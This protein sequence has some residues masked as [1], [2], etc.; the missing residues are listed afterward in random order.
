MLEA[1][2]KLTTNFGYLFEEDLISEISEL[3][4]S[5][6]FIEDSKII[7]VGDY[8]RSMP[9]LISGA[10]KILREDEH[11]EELV[12]YYLEKGDTCAMTLSCCMGQ[13]KS[14]IR[15]VA[16]TNVE[17][18]MLPKE[19]MLEWLGKYKTWQTYI[20]QSYHSRMDELL[21]AVD[22]IAFL[23][24]DERL[25]KYL[26]DKAMVVH[27]DVLHVTHKEISEDLHT[28]RVVISRL[29]KKLENEGKIKLFRN[30][31]KVLEL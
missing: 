26:K 4:I 12:L 1:I 24:M 16:E 18:I 10:I 27:N 17:L 11:G 15:A 31:I 14:K 21:E 23:K 25:F 19:K 22:T 9:L 7:E 29:L 8:I 2:N 28:S 6:A 30:S 20:L 13:T 3:G 5:K